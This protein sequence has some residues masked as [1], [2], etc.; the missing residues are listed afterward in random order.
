VE[1]AADA[2]VDIDDLDEAATFAPALAHAAAAAAA[3]APAPKIAAPPRVPRAAAAAAAAADEAATLRTAAT[4]RS[5]LLDLVRGTGELDLGAADALD[6][7]AEA[8]LAAKARPFLVLDVRDDDEY[9]RG[10]ILH[11]EGIQEFASTAPGLT[12]P[13][14]R[15]LPPHAP[16][17]VTKLLHAP[18]PGL[19]QPRLFSG[20][21]GVR[22]IEDS[23]ICG[24][25]SRSGC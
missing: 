16:V 3:S 17:A 20:D 6:P 11:G 25:G 7:A 10:H 18:H 22:G 13:C 19:R 24:C 2:P 12:P 9:S 4:A 15:Q 8:R 23:L 21:A 5:T 14:S 1:S